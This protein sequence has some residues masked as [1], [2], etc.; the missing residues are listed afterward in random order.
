MREPSASTSQIR[1]IRNG[2]NGRNIIKDNQQWEEGRGGVLGVYGRS[3]LQHRGQCHSKTAEEVLVGAA[4]RL[5]N[6]PGAG[7]RVADGTYPSY[8]R[9]CRRRGPSR[10]RGYHAWPT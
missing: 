9:T 7:S 8:Y 3:A 5:H 1:E 4:Q 6:Q 2:S 10:R